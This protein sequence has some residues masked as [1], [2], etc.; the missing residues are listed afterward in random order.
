MED[1]AF[2]LVLKGTHKYWIGSNRKKK[3]HEKNGSRTRSHVH[4][5]CNSSKAQA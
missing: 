5:G 2:V 4:R 3:E 1:V